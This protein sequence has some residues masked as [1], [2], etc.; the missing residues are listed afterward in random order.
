MAIAVILSLGTLVGFVGLNVRSGIASPA[1]WLVYLA[2][3][4]GMASIIY[5]VPA[6]VIVLVRR[7]RW[8]W[9]L[10]VRLSVAWACWFG[11]FAW[12][13]PHDVEENYLSLIYLLLIVG[14]L[15]A[16]V[17]SAITAPSRPAPES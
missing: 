7:A 14:S 16:V 9:P 8:H 11:G 15:A 17:H 5:L 10:S 6:I 13:V 1:L 12:L 4:L 3:M 2:L